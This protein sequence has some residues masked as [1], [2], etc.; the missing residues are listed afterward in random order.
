MMFFA[1]V[2]KAGSHMAGI[3]APAYEDNVSFALHTVGRAKKLDHP[4]PKI[5]IDF[6]NQRMIQLLSSYLKRPTSEA[7]AVPRR[8]PGPTRAPKSAPKL[9][10]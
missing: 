9:T 7:E 3:I 5:Q 1:I 2:T 10:Q 8:S 6:M 4:P